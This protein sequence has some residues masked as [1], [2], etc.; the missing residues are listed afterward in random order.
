MSDKKRIL[1]VEDETPVAMMMAFLLTR[2]GYA[3]T[4]AN[5]GPNAVALAATQKFDLITID[6]CLPAFQG[7][8]VCRQLKEQ[9]LCQ[10]TSIIFVTAQLQEVHGE[11][12]AELGVVDFIE[13]P[14]EVSDFVFR[15]SR[16]LANSSAGSVMANHH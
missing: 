1:V 11:R 13:K 16:L 14:F 12:A 7:F 4:V 15:I 6:L 8:E 9:P 3:V 5:S 10:A 2:V